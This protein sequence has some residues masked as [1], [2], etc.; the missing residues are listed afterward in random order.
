[1]EESVNISSI[2][3]DTFAI[4]KQDINRIPLPGECVKGVTSIRGNVATVFDLYKFLNIKPAGDDY[5]VVCKDEETEKNMVFPV[6]DIVGILKKDETDNIS[7]V[8]SIHGF[9]SSNIKYNDQI[10]KYLCGLFE[11][12]VS[13]DVIIFVDDNNKNK[14]DFMTNKNA[15]ACVKK[16]IG[17]NKSKFE[18]NVTGNVEDLDG[19]IEVTK[20]DDNQKIKIYLK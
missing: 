2:I 6:S 1:M 3:R 20:K 16:M 11:D 18:V 13:D 19:T 5:F 9:V 4:K 7:N 10:D 12:E 17:L 15:I 14:F 8:D